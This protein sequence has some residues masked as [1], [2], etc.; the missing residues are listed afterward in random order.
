MSGYIATIQSNRKELE[1][2]TQFWAQEESSMVLCGNHLEGVD[3]LVEEV[4]LGEYAL[5][6]L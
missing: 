3:W 5:L 4:Q 1:N 6:R 2:V